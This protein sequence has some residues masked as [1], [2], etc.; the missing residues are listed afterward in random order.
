MAVCGM[1]YEA[2]VDGAVRGTRFPRREQW[3]SQNRGIVLVRVQLRA[4]KIAELVP[5][6][7][8]RALSWIFS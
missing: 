7:A 3:T 8:D 1:A 6:A 5:I 2:E 4:R